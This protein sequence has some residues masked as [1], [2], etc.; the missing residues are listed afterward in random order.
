[1][2]A[3]RVKYGQWQGLQREQRTCCQCHSGRGEDITHW[4]LEYDEGYTEHQ[5]LIQLL[6]F[7]VNNDEERSDDDRVAIMIRYVSISPS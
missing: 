6:S 3:H 4:L 7:I 5:L 1:M 2:L